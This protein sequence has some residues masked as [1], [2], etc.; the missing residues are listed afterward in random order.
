[1]SKKN[2][3]KN[4][5]LKKAIIKHILMYVAFFI[6][7]V[8]LCTVCIFSVM[9]ALNIKLDSVDTNHS[10]HLI[11]YIVLTFSVI[12][13]ILYLIVQRNA[14]TIPVLHIR[15][16]L[17]RISEGDFET[18]LP[19]EKTLFDISEFNPIINDLNKATRELREVSNTNVDFI[20][21]VSHEFKTPLAVIQNYSK[22]LQDENLPTEK[23][24]EYISIINNSVEDLNSL[25][26]NA[27]KLN[28]LEHQ[29]IIPKKE[30]FDLIEQIVEAIL[31]FEKQ[32]EEKN[33]NLEVNLDEKI[34]VSTEKNLLNHIWLNLIS[35]AIK[36][37][38]NSGDITIIA[39]VIDDSAVVTIADSGCG[40]K[41]ED[42]PFIFDKYYRGNI[43]SNSNGNGLGLPLVKRICD[44][45][46][47]GISFESEFEKGSTFVIFINL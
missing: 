2:E 15:Q 31:V 19:L 42:K 46:D 11:G 27:L 30:N 43:A 47:I 39:K 29:N 36:F 17:Q 10:I 21:N 26:T 8:L 6:S 37:N 41:E 25:V 44:V 40:I 7:N 16:H 1:M 32:L 18:E 5:V 4:A 35:N 28:R 24:N 45:L 9:H 33:I 20:N 38:K 3:K 12:F 22:L 13:L 34:I 23:R 14:I